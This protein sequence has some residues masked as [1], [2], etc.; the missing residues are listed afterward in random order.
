[1]ESLKNPIEKF[2]GFV[3]HGG[4]R[5]GSVANSIKAVIEASEEH[6]VVMSAMPMK[7][8]LYMSEDGNCIT[9]LLKRDKIYTVHSLKILQYNIVQEKHICLS[10]R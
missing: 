10:I 7:N 2:E 9:A 8:T 3:E 5:Q 1:M 4:S 6:E